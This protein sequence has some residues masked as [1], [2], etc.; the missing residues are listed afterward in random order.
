MITTAE[1]GFVICML[2]FNFLW[3]WPMVVDFPSL[4]VLV[5]LQNKCKQN[6]LIWLYGVVYLYVPGGVLKIF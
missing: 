3:G 1:D 5:Y 4:G 2:N 6:D